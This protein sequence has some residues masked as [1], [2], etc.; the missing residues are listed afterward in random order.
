MVVPKL[1]DG[2][3]RLFFLFNWEGLRETKSLTSTPS[4]PLTPWRTGDF[5]SCATP[6]AT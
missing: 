1:L 2:K 4:V 3:D 5:S 6:T